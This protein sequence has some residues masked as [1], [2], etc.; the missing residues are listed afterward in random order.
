[1]LPRYWS[2]LAGAAVRRERSSQGLRLKP[3]LSPAGYAPG[4]IALGVL[5]LALLVLA[6]W[7]FPPPAG[8]FGYGVLGTCA[9]V[10]LLGGVIAW[11][12]HRL[13]LAE[14]NDIKQ[15]EQR[16]ALTMSA[17]DEAFWDWKVAGD[18]LYVSPRLL[19]MFDFPPDTTFPGR[20]ALFERLAIPA[21]DR[22]ALDRAVGEHFAGK[23]ARMETEF[24]ALVRGEER[25][26]HATGRATR[27]DAG[28][29]VRWNG[30]LRDITA[31]RR[32]EEALRRSEERFR[33][34][35]ELSS[36][37]FWEAD[38]EHRYTAIEAGRAYTGV[39][40]NAS[41]LGRARWEIPYASPDEAAW[42]AHRAVIAARERFVDFRFSRI[43]EGEE[44][45]YEH[46]GEPR[47]DAQGSFVGYR[48]VGRDVTARKR[49]EEALR[50]S[51]Q[52]YERAMAASESGYW[53]WHIPT[54]RYF[55]SPRAHEL[56]GFP[57]EHKWANRADYRAHI[58]MHPED[59]AR[60]EAARKD[61][62]AGTG[63]RLAME[64]RY[65][66]R[67][68]TRWHNLQA[69]CTR[70]ETG[71]VVRWS[72][73]A[74]DVTARKLAQEGLRESEKRY[75]RVMQ[76]SEE[77]FWE[78]VVATDAFYASPRM[79][80][81]YGLP[82]DTVFRGRKDFMSRIPFHPEDL[83]SWRKA[84]AA[85]LAG[86][87]PRVDLE[88][89]AILK[90]GAGWIHLTGI[91][92][93]DASGAEERWT[94]SVSDV[95]ERKRAED[96]LRLSEARYARAMDASADGLWEWNAATDELFIS[97]RAREL[98][99]IPDGIEI[100]TRAE[101][102]AQNLQFTED[103]IR[104]CI[105]QRSGIEMTYSVLNQSGELRWVRSTGKVFLGGHGEPMLVTGSLT[106]VTERKLAA[107]A[108]RLSEEELRARQDMLDLAQKAASAAAFEWHIGAGE[109]EN[110][111]SPDLEVMYGLQPGSYDGSYE[112]WKKLVLPADWPAVEAAIERA[113]ETGDVAAE[114]RVVHPDGAIRWLQAKGRM[115][116]D[117]QRK[118]ARVVGFML[119]VTDRHQAD[120]ELRRLERQLRQ[121]QRLEAMGTFAGG[122]A[123]DF[124]NILGAILGYGEMVLRGVPKES[125]LA[126]DLDS[127][128]TAG[129]RGRALVGR[130]LAFSRSVVG[131]RVPVHVERVVREALDLVSAKLPPGVTVQAQLHA[132]RA[133]ILGDETQVHQVVANLATNA[134]QAMSA[135]GALRVELA[136]VRV[137]ASRA[138]TIGGLAVGEYVVLTVADTG[139]GIP[140]EILE[141]IFDPFF[142]TKEVGT[143]TGL[144]LS[145][146]HGIV[147]E[148]GGGIDLM[149]KVGAGTTFSVYLPRSGEAPGA[150]DDA[151][152]LALPRGDG[153]RVLVVDDEEPLVRLATR[154]LEELGY[155]P[156]G[157]TSSS[158]AFAAFRADPQRFDALITDERMPGMSGAALIREV[159]G[160]RSA[161][162]VVLM[163]GYLGPMARKARESGLLDTLGVAP[164][165]AAAIG[166]DEVLQKPLSAHDLA[167]SLAR[168]LRL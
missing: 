54:D 116:F 23:S 83:A 89:R 56:S 19:E 72:G 141:R 74:T 65:I 136:S 85:H 151:P 14:L 94:G 137:G 129:E 110:R 70:D 132:G 147:M 101:L 125:R 126:R 32:A 28:A 154:T 157:F 67:G 166:A 149:T 68:E 45:F 8:G 99:G 66:V 102:K 142:T 90:D 69:I 22:E 123:H 61:L 131:E 31:R 117:E 15:S 93:R 34:L 49:A 80:A 97:L 138:A 25:W 153:Q 1:M 27:D 143:G 76:A 92:L 29:V 26:I 43:E 159:R 58:P 162:P 118:P 5:A 88:V 96:A 53:D 121:A 145:L 39:R 21:E 78:W 119:D 150:E 160:V 2:C 84:V 37:F 122:I 41:K 107:D 106:D 51:E 79:L 13:L 98:W 11:R 40:N 48:G 114:Y 35:T 18:E 20:G 146:V 4:R 59:M 50:E 111:S 12:R 120:E 7:R 63:E 77:G 91:C 164:K 3:G 95:T 113:N 6:A 24:R 86:E 135:G 128:V 130:L 57:R 64:V 144:G 104:E 148:L 30:A 60:W 109:G 139:A 75:E 161:M 81:I 44:R 71:K 33:S 36:D 16:Y 82:P 73:S 100:R 55:A 108:L 115:F 52:R 112:T 133:A 10:L 47:Y 152:P 105:A 140:P 103:T 167:T 9:L 165:V 46:S 168:V 155:A 158:A 156:V 38:A 17:S 42:A 87:I 163:S 127:I 124:N 134:I 62:F